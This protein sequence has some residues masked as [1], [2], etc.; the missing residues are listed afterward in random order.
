VRCERVGSSGAATAHWQTASWGRGAAAGGVSVQHAPF[1][2]AGS[3][4]FS[5]PLAASVD[6]G[7]S[8]ALFGSASAGVT[9]DGSHFFTAGLLGASGLTVSAGAGLEFPAQALASVQVV[10]FFGAVVARGTL[11]NAGQGAAILS[12]S[13]PTMD[14]A[15]A[16][17]LFTARLGSIWN[18]EPLCSRRFRGAQLDA[19]T[20]RFSRGARLTPRSECTT[21]RVEALEWQRVEF[22]RGTTVEAVDVSMAADATVQEAPIA[23][24]ARHRALVLSAGM[25]PG[26]QNAGETDYVPSAE[27]IDAG[28][29]DAFRL[30]HAVF[31]LP[32]DDRLHVVRGGA[33]TDGGAQAAADGA[34]RFTGFVVQFEP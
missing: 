34:A 6:A 32:A 9:V 20:L 17:P 15:R 12:V 8:F 28:L 27:L 2:L 33:A 7:A 11:S 1:S 29:G 22:P 25:G 21:A 30:A 4:P 24:V 18:D 16:L 14:P 3:S 13:T 10:E 23:P 31:T 5:R 26:G 19:S